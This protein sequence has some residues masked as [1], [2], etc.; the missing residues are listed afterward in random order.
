MHDYIA[1]ATTTLT[2]PTTLTPLTTR[3]ELKRLGN[4]VVMRMASLSLLLHH[5]RHTHSHPPA[6]MTGATAEAKHALKRGAHGRTGTRRCRLSRGSH[7]TC[8]GA[9]LEPLALL[10]DGDGVC[11]RVTAVSKNVLPEFRPDATQNPCYT[12]C[13]GGTRQVLALM[14]VLARLHSRTILPD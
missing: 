11:S 13:H 8:R 3:W 10:C 4:H 7:G 2:P 5:G 1:V 14:P 12:L 6:S 9:G